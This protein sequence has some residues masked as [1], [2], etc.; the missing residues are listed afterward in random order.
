VQI[1]DTYKKPTRIGIKLGDKVNAKGK[2]IKVRYAKTNDK[3]I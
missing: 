3:D 1:L 2:A